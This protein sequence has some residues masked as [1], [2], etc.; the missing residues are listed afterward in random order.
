MPRRTRNIYKR[1][2]GRYE[3]RYIR[4]R[5]PNGKA[6]YRSLYAHSYA[7]VK[8]RLEL[9]KSGGI[10]QRLNCSAT[11]AQAVSGYLDNAAGYLKQSTIG[12]YRGLLNRHIV[13]F[14]AD[15]RCDRLTS[16]IMNTFV[17]MKSGGLSSST[18]KSAYS[19]IKAGVS[20]VYATCTA[21]DIKFPK[22]KNGK[23]GAAACL[24]VSEQRKLENAAQSSNDA[25]YGILYLSL[26]TGIRL[27]ELSALDWD[28]ID[29][30]GKSLY[31]H[32]TMQRICSD[33]DTK[34]KIAFLSPKSESSTRHIPLPDFLV[35]ILSD[36]K[37]K[38]N[39]E[40]VISRD[41]KF[42]EPRS[43]Q[44]H[45]KKLLQSAGI[46]HVNF[47]TLRHTFAT[48]ALECGFDVKSLSEILG[49][50]SATV[51]LRT[52]AHALDGQRRRCMDS[53][54][55]VWYSNVE[56]GQN[57]GQPGCKIA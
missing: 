19:L 12:V 43:V 17:D 40:Y 50:A 13:P 20:A 4:D 26:Y 55:S 23:R 38:S 44:N 56:S 34:T 47:H 53:L 30:F 5:D 15:M 10:P 36:L 29:I 45:F 6:I 54:S 48:R 57:S 42:I 37:A 52:Y 1:N 31:I 46:R 22:N 24:S 25:D 8:S 2:D 16:E 39:S 33:G 11:V 27:G 21:F 51:T 3:A 7:E 28:D 9:A 14:F 18:V 49:H 35:K 32:R 41:G